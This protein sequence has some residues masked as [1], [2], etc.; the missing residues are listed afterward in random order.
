TTLFRSA[1]R[2]RPSACATCGLRCSR[3]RVAGTVAPAQAGAHFFK[4]MGSRLR[5]NDVLVAFAGTTYWSPSRERQ[6]AFPLR[7]VPGDGDEVGGTPGE[8]EEVPDAVEVPEALV[9]GVEG[10]A[11]R[12]EDA[13]AEEPGE[14]GRPEPC[15]ERLQRDKPHPAHHQIEDKRERARALAEHELLHD[16]ERGEAPRDAQQRPAPCPSQRDEREGR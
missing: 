3:N 13:A 4:H 8:D 10:D 7:D 9:E 16:A 6:P 1:P 5:G 2:A 15:G 14:P 12:V 11:R